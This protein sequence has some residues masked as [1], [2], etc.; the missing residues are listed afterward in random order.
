MFGSVLCGCRGEVD[1]RIGLGLYQSC[2]NWGGGVRRVSVLGL[3]WC[4]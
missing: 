1:E 2:E 4:G 3:R